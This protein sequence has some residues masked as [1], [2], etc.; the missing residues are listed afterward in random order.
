MIFIVTL[1]FF[2]YVISSVKV[3]QNLPIYVCKRKVG[4]YYNLV[5]FKYWVKNKSKYFCIF[6]SNNWSSSTSSFRAMDRVRWGGGRE[7]TY[8]SSLLGCQMWKCTKSR[9]A[10]PR[11]YSTNITGRMRRHIFY[12]SCQIF[13]G[14][15][16]PLHA[17][18][19]TTYCIYTNTR[20]QTLDIWILSFLTCRNEG[21]DL[22]TYLLLT[23]NYS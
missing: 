13:H 22:V 11:T 8:F 17:F 21:E 15:K 14:K 5:P 2:T 1:T 4:S 7:S 10:V 19:R 3:K 6:A 23:D 18:G 16:T 20:P 9:A 12:I